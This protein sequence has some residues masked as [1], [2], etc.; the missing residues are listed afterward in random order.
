MHLVVM[1]G[2]G[3][4]AGVLLTGYLAANVP[5]RYEKAVLAVASLLAC[6]SLAAWLVQKIAI[7]SVADINEHVSKQIAELMEHIRIDV[8]KDVQALLRLTLAEQSVRLGAR[9]LAALKKMLREEADAAADQAA[10][11]V[12][13]N[14]TLARA[15]LPSQSRDNVLPL[16]RG[17]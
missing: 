16:A 14:G 3:L 8:P 12:V 6:A 10:N 4:V 2:A 17:E 7:A 9:Q 13:R 1:K 15:Y 11:K 5:P